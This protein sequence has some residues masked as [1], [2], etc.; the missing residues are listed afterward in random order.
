M[1][2]FC[3]NM[4]H[5]LCLYFQKY[6]KPG[7]TKQSFL[8]KNLESAEF[9]DKKHRKPTL[10]SL[11]ANHVLEMSVK[12]RFRCVRVEKKHCFVLVI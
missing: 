9:T 3:P 12:P 10:H 2:I 7:F 1:I 11:I 6:Q 4:I 5:F 8:H